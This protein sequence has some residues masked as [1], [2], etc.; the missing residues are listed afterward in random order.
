MGSG[1]SDCFPAACT[2]AS[3]GEFFGANK[4]SLFTKGRSLHFNY[5]TECIKLKIK[6]FG[7]L[8]IIISHI[9]LDTSSPYPVEKGLPE[10]PNINEVL[11]DFADDLPKHMPFSGVLAIQVG[12]ELVIDKAFNPVG[13]S[14]TT[15]QVFNCFSTG[16]IFTA[17]AALQLEEDGQ[18]DLD[19]PISKYLSSEE[20]DIPLNPP[21]LQDKPT[22]EDLEKFKRNLNKITIRDLLNHCSGLVQAPE[23]PP[24]RFFEKLPKEIEHPYSN[25]GYQLL[26]VIIGKQ[27]KNSKASSPEDRFRDHVEQRIFYPSG[28]KV[29]NESILHLMISIKKTSYN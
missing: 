16:K 15:E 10:K 26:A 21:Y 4:S 9:N 13:L 12:N 29:R 25:Y 19:T 17:V 28:M 18:L 23:G 1:I 5:Y 11:T 8:A 3:K 27:T 6:K 24:E 14:F 7:Y 22:K 20:V 2:E